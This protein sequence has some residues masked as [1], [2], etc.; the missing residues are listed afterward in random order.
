MLYIRTK[1]SD[2]DFLRNLIDKHIPLLQKSTPDEDNEPLNITDSIQANFEEFSFDAVS[3]EYLLSQWETVKKH[4]KPDG[5]RAD[6]FLYGIDETEDSFYNHLGSSKT[7]KRTSS[8]YSLEM[9]YET[10]EFSDTE[11]ASRASAKLINITPQELNILQQKL[12][13]KS[14]THSP[15][16]Q[17]GTYTISIDAE[18]VSSL[19]GFVGNA[20]TAENIRQNQSFISTTDIGKTIFSKDFSLANNPSFPHSAY[21]T[22][23]DDEGIT[24]EPIKLI[25]NGTIKNLLID[26]KNSKKFNLPATGN[27]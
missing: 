12:V 10:G 5:M 25:E 6:K 21:N 15:K 8:S 19:L 18:V 7:Q 26:S 17:S 1:N 3:K 4:P 24:S 2:A 11:A 20:L 23:F 27:G 22:L 13:N 14:Q 9:H 16:L